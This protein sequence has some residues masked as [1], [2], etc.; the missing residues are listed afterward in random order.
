LASLIYPYLIQEKGW[1]K[2]VHRRLQQYDLVFG[3]IVLVILDLSV[4]VVGAEILYPRGLHVTDIESLARLL[5]EVMGRI[6]FTVF[7]LG[8]FAALFGSIVGRGVGYGMLLSDAYF[9]WRR[10]GIGRDALRQRI[11]AWS[12]LWIVVSPLFWVLTGHTDFVGAT[13]LVSTAQVV[14]I[15]PLVG[16]LWIITAR[17]R[18]IGA[19]YRNRWWENALMAILFLLACVGGYFGLIKTWKMLM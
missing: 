18:Y 11:Y 4:W 19:Q 2:P 13:L 5:G 3:I 17:E 16:G 9:H 1:S 10:P 15:P 14:I 7:Y 12:V 6:G 8:V